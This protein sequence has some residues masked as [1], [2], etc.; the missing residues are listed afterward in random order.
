MP[1]TIQ[2]APPS[3]L[4]GA[5]KR[6]RQRLLARF[7]TLSLALVAGVS[8][9]A[10]FFVFFFVARD[11]IPFFSGGHVREFF[12]GTRWQPSANPP[13]FGALAIFAGTL[14]VTILSCA[15]A[16]PLGICAAVA[17]SDMLNPKLRAIVKSVV[18][19][20]AAIPSVA[21]GFFA[22]VVVA[23][24]MQNLGVPRGTNALNA[25][26]LLALMALPTIV[27]I[28]EDALR[29][30]PRDIREGS[31]ALGATRGETLV[32]AV[33]PAARGGIA[34]ACLLGVMRALGETMVVWMA[35]GNS[36]QFPS[37]WY[38]IFSPIR[39]LTAT[40]VGEMGEADH[41]TGS[42]RYAAL[43]TMA[44]FLLVISFTINM[45]GARLARKAVK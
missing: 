44:L 36:A 29:A 6:F 18:E 15:I 2:Q 34:A 19:V 10:V 35:S 23:P 16:I 21:F 7:G 45:I 9:A 13:G 38:N 24:W 11:S 31:F 40:I 37:P 8:V 12:L 33:I 42:Q 5:A 30:V 41:A 20:L 26:L 17:I 32:R 1:S 22:L 4:T 43:F 39:T 25:S 27:S 3:L 14:Y 28:S